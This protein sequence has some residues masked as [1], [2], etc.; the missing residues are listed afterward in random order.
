[1]IAAD[2]AEVIRKLDLDLRLGE[3]GAET[4]AV[5]RLYPG[6]M[7]VAPLQYSRGHDQSYCTWYMERAYEIDRILL[8][9]SCQ[10][11]PR[12]EDQPQRY[13]QLSAR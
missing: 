12:N 4:S 6:A 1:M 3:D 11:Q 5:T 2:D 10:I 9:S 13:C 7:A 8:T